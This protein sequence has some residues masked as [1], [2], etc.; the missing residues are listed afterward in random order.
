MARSIYIKIIEFKKRIQFNSVRFN[1][2]STPPHNDAWRSGT[3]GML[4]S[5]FHNAAQH[6]GTSHISPYKATE[7]ACRVVQTVD[8]RMRGV[9]TGAFRKQWRQAGKPELVSFKMWMQWLASTLRDV[10]GTERGRGGM[11]DVGRSGR[12]C[13]LENIWWNAYEMQHGLRCFCGAWMRRHTQSN[14]SSRGTTAVS[15]A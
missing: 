3:A 10:I 13:M 9:C 8:R 7:A 6:H 4:E 11:V 12:V 14:D 1:S 15:R 2:M 5:T